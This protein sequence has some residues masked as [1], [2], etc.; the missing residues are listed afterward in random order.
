MLAPTTARRLDIQELRSQQI[1][2]VRW[3]EPTPKA[4]RKALI[5]EVDDLQCNKKGFIYLCTY[6]HAVG[7]DHRTQVRHPGIKESADLLRAVAGANTKD[8]SQGVD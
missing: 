7:P 6:I 2:C 3:P 1:Y 8:N 5:K 4:I